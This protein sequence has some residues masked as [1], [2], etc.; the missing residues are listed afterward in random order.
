MP[1][2]AFSRLSPILDLDEKLGLDS[3][4]AVGDALAVGLGLANQRSEPLLQIR[5]G[6]FIETVVNLAGIDKFFPLGPAEIDAIPL[7]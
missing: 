2:F 7:S 6:G 5:G 1:H 4:A 3:D